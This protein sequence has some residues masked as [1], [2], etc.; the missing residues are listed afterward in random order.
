MFCPKFYRYLCE[1]DYNIYV[2][3]VDLAMPAQM[4]DERPVLFFWI[5][6]EVNYDETYR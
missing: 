2:N 6:P 4:T 1:E 5:S 3:T